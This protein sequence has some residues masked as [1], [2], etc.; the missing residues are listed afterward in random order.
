MASANLYFAYG[1]NMVAA[2]MARRCPGASIVGIAQ[3]SDY[4]FQITDRGGATVNPFPGSVVY[5]VL[6]KLKLT[7]RHLDALDVYEGVP[8][9][10]R[11]ETKEVLQDGRPMEAEIYIA[12]TERE[13]R[14]W[15]GYLERIIGA[16]CNHR[17]PLGYIEQLR[18][19]G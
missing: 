1:A 8:E 14:P 10:Y 5:G 11:R 19:L 3:L 18:L 13:G 17:F 15:P 4:R 12:T 2:D 9:W 16:A 6:W 7:E